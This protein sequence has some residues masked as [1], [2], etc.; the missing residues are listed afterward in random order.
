MSSDSLFESG[1]VFPKDGPA[2]LSDPGA[3]RLVRASFIELNA[4]H[5]NLVV[6]LHPSITSVL[7]T[8]SQPKIPPTIVEPI[9]I[10][11]IYFVR[12]PTPRH[13][14][15]S[16]TGAGVS[17]SVNLNVPPFFIASGSACDFSDF[18]SRIAGHSVD[19]D[20]VAGL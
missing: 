20:P 6:A 2:V 18:C 12:R 11:V 15:D 7:G 4:L 1:E 8:R 17:D 13:I 19:H 14:Q 9:V 10:Q 3:V 16:E 5:A